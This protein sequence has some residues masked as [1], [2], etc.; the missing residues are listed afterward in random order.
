MDHQEE[1]RSAQGNRHGLTQHSVAINGTGI[2]AI[3]SSGT[4]V[5]MIVFF[6]SQSMGSVYLFAFYNEAPYLCIY[7]SA[8]P[9]PIGFYVLYFMLLPRCGRVCLFHRCLG[10][11]TRPRRRTRHCLCGLCPILRVTLTYR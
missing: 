7:I 6:F 3:T 5:V 1:R 2:Q 8:R 9:H 10:T 4:L 11:V